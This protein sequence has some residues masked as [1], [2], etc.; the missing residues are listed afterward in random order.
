MNGPLAEG[1]WQ[2]CIKEYKTLVKMDVWEEVEREG[3]MNILPGT[4]AFK[5]K[6]FPDGLVWKLK[7]RF[8]AMGNHQVENVDYF[9]TFAPVVTWNT[10]RILLAMSL[11]LKLATKQVDY[12]AA[13]D[14]APIDKPPGYDDMMDLEK[15]QSGVYIEMPRSFDEEKSGKVLKFNK[16]LY[17]LKQSSRNFFLFLKGNLEAVGL[18]QQSEA[19][20]CLFVNDKV[21]RIMYVDATLFFAKEMSDIDDIIEDLQ[22]TIWYSKW[23]MTLLDF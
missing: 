4:W 12:T 15:E 9:E 8:C 7:A 14:H 2:A 3:W 6:R 20:P 18:Q 13:F 11:L 22:K 16:S 10:V 17:G 21:I 5:C 19:D 23:K 1:Y